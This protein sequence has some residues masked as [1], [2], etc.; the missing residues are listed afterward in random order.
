M[1]K[2]PIPSDWDGLNW[3]CR[4]II[5]PNSPIWRA[6][7]RGVLSN[8]T[9]G[10]FW[11]ETTGTILGAKNVAQFTFQ[12][13]LQSTGCG[14]CPPGPPGPQGPTG[15]QGPQGPTGPQGPQGP[16]GP[17]GPQGPTGPQGPQGPTG[18]Q[19]TQ[20]PTGP[21]GPQGP[22]GEC[23]CRHEPVDVPEP[24]PGQDMC[25]DM[26]SGIV[27]WLQGL[28]DD[29]QTAI[30]AGGLALAVVGILALALAVV[31]G[32]PLSIPLLAAVAS[33]FFE[34]LDVGFE[35]AFTEDTWQAVKCAL[36]AACYDGYMAVVD[37]QSE[38][39]SAKV[40]FTLSPAEQ[41]GIDVVKAVVGLMGDDGLV[42]TGVLNLVPGSD[43]SGC[44][45]GPGDDCCGPGE[46]Y[47]D[48]LSIC[49]EGGAREHLIPCLQ[50]DDAGTY[51]IVFSFTIV[52]GP[53]LDED[54]NVDWATGFAVVQYEYREDRWATIAGSESGHPVGTH[55]VSQDVS[56]PAGVNLRV[57][58][59]GSGAYPVYITVPS[60]C[61]TL[62]E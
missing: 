49:G 19:G 46:V 29:I 24:E 37:A 42:N 6:V 23:D 50:V 47:C 17:Q 43:C 41:L 38:L 48:G 2:T 7:W 35:N 57:K 39:E 34:I 3:V 55:Y 18:P 5:I 56:L 8:P 4:E 26:A 21:Q 58:I 36:Y 22:A 25:C 11:D 9:R 60:V 12:S 51:R 54:C 62:L 10:R 1:P 13:F 52:P 40:A 33:L 61:V 59:R 16:A 27:A 30:D 31:V 32:G 28:V 15:P 53:Q 20:G 44:G 45:Q 14:D